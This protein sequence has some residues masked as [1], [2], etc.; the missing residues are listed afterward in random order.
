MLLTDSLVVG[1]MLEWIGILYASIKG[2][3]SLANIRKVDPFCEH[4]DPFIDQRERM[5]KQAVHYL[6]HIQKHGAPEPFEEKAQEQLKTC[7]SYLDELTSAKNRLEHPL[8]NEDIRDVR[9]VKMAITPLHNGAHLQEWRG[10]YLWN[11]LSDKWVG[12][13]T[14][15][16]EHCIRSHDTFPYQ[17]WVIEMLTRQIE[18]LVHGVTSKLNVREAPVKPTLLIHKSQTRIWPIQ[19]ILPWRMLVKSSNLKDSRPSAMHALY[20]ATRKTQCCR[21]S[22]RKSWSHSG[23]ARETRGHGSANKFSLL[24]PMH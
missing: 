22:T 14:T 7:V 4:N 15:L 10:D 17:M 3:V 8:H 19:T 21:T 13:L 1:T 20:I 9:I 24:E 2:V 6:R 23:Y 11:A 18:D 16:P 5:F 12:F